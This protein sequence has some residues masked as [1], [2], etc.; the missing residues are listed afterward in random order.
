[1]A[2]FKINEFK[3]MYVFLFIVIGLL[4]FLAMIFT[5]TQFRNK[6]Q[7]SSGNSSNLPQST[8][9]SCVPNPNFP[10]TNQGKCS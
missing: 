1:M 3:F 6:L 4:V 10:N 2:N 8:A 5:N 9:Q 7:A